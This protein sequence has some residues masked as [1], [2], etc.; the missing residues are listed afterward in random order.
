MIGAKLSDQRNSRN[1]SYGGFERR[2]NGGKP[3]RDAVGS[4]A[5]IG[6]FETACIP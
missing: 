2:A 4:E 1:A 5:L 3:W 6:R